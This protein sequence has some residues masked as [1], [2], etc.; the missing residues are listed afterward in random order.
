MQKLFPRRPGHGLWNILNFNRRVFHPD[1]A[2]RF[3]FGLTSVYNALPNYIVSLQTV[4]EFQH[5]LTDLAR[6]LVMDMAIGK[7]SYHLT[8]LMVFGDFICHDRT[9]HIEANLLS[10]ILSWCVE[11]QL[12]RLCADRFYSS[13]R[14]SEEFLKLSFVYPCLCYNLRG[15]FRV[16]RV[17]GGCPFLKIVSQPWRESSSNSLG[18]LLVGSSGSCM[19]VMTLK[20]HVLQTICPQWAD[21]HLWFFAFCISHIHIVHMAP[22]TAT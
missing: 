10:N 7:H 13:P 6:Q 8:A 1:L 3:L 21:W 2:K 19:I 17:R 15:F 12:I 18:W 9:F 4:Q 11:V 14:F 20:H 5:E 22:W 16:F